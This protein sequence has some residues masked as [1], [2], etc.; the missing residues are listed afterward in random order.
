MNSNGFTSNIQTMVDESTIAASSTINI[1]SPISNST[2]AE[3]PAFG[4]SFE[5]VE[6]SPVV[7]AFGTSLGTSLD[8]FNAQAASSSETYCRPGQ[9]TPINFC[10]SDW[11]KCW[12]SMCPDLEKLPLIELR[13]EYTNYD[14][15]RSISIRYSYH[16]FTPTEWL[17]PRSILEDRNLDLEEVE[18]HEIE[19]IYY[20][21]ILWHL[22]SRRINSESIRDILN[23]DTLR[24]EQQEFLPIALYIVEISLPENIQ[25]LVGLDSELNRDEQQYTLKSLQNNC[26]IISNRINDRFEIQFKANQSYRHA[27]SI[28]E[29]T[30]IDDNSRSPII[31]TG[32]ILESPML[33]KNESV[34]DT[35]GVEI[36]DDLVL[37]NYIPIMRLNIIDPNTKLVMRP[38]MRN[39]ERVQVVFY[40]MNNLTKVYKGDIIGSQLKWVNIIP[41]MA[42]IDRPQTVYWIVWLGQFKNNKRVDPAK[43]TKESYTIISLDLITSKLTVDIN[44]K[45]HH[46]YSRVLDIISND[47]KLAVKPS[48]IDGS[49]RMQ[50]RHIKA[51]VNFYGVLFDQF[52]F[53]HFVQQG[54]VYGD[55][56]EIQTRWIRDY[57]YLLE[58]SRSVSE[59]N[60]HDY[61]FRELSDVEF[62]P[63]RFSIKQLFSE[64]QNNLH[65]QS[66][67]SKRVILLDENKS[68]D[69]RPINEPYVE[70]IIKNARSEIQLQ[71]F[72][73]ILSSILFL[74]QGE[75]ERNNSQGETE[76]IVFREEIIKL[77]SGWFP[78]V[79]ETD[80]NN[81]Q[82]WSSSFNVI[83]NPL[84]EGT[85]QEIE[86]VKVEY[87]FEELL[88]YFTELQ[89]VNPEMANLYIIE[90]KPIFPTTRCIKEEMEYFIAKGRG[91]TNGLFKLSVM[92]RLKRLAPEYKGLSRAGGQN[93]PRIL[94]P[95][96]VELWRQAGWQVLGFPLDDPKHYFTARIQDLRF[97]GLGKSNKWDNGVVPK[98]FAGY[99]ESQKTLLNAGNVIPNKLRGTNTKFKTRKILTVDG[100]GFLP[101][102]INNILRVRYGN[103]DGVFE[104]HGLSGNA[105]RSKNSA[106][107]C[108][109]TALL[110]YPQVL[111]QTV[112][113]L[114]NDLNHLI[115]VRKQAMNMLSRY[116][117]PNED[118]RE[119][120][121]SNIRTHL[122]PQ[123]IHPGLLRQELFDHT[124][125][126][127]MDLLVDEN[128]YFDPALFY[129]ALEELFNVN[130]CVFAYPDWKV[131]NEEKSTVDI[132]RHRAFHVAYVHEERHTVFMIK[133]DGAETDNAQYP[134]CEMI[135]YNQSGKIQTVFGSE[136]TGLASIL[137]RLTNSTYTWSYLSGRVVTRLNMY[138]H[139]LTDTL[140]TTATSQFIDIYGK[141]RALT[142]GNNE[143]TVIVPPSAPVNLPV[144][145][146]LIQ[147]NWTDVLDLFK[148]Q[149]PI[150]VSKISI[151]DVIWVTGLWYPYLDLTY[152]I[153]IPINPVTPDQL[154]NNYNAGLSNPL[155]APMLNR[156][157]RIGN[158]F[159]M[160]SIIKQLLHWLFSIYRQVSKSNGL[161]LS[162]IVE[163][164]M[165][166]YLIVTD[167]ASDV[168]QLTGQV[169]L[170]SLD[171]YSMPIKNQYLPR[172]LIIEVAWDYIRNYN[173]H[174]VIRKPDQTSALL[175]YP[176]ALREKIHYTLSVYNRDTLLLPLTER[177]T[178]T[179]LYKYAEDFK[180]S[181]RMNIFMTV[182][183]L[184]TW[185][186]D[187]ARLRAKPHS[188]I[189]KISY[190]HM[191]TKDPFLFA[192]GED[193][194][195]F[196]NVFQ[197]NLFR[198]RHVAE[199][200]L[201]RK[202]N[203]G[204]NAPP[205]NNVFSANKKMPYVLYT[206]S[207]GSTIIPIEDHRENSPNFLRILEYSPDNVAI[208]QSVISGVKL[209]S[210][211]KTSYAALLLL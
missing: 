53:A 183:E 20:V 30:L 145:N 159:R 37:N 99:E 131:S 163:N 201:K 116:S 45:K 50:M 147:A 93:K 28:I 127:I 168:Q 23:D 63:T 56:S 78:F 101:I 114:N 46:S 171:L 9:Y 66:L 89:M 195:I 6:V 55:E 16:F 109:M 33:Y 103:A 58:A 187:L 40:N 140:F 85:E 185:F 80:T 129:R 96:E 162:N 100:R 27:P 124:D 158:M 142:I 107:H 204:Y 36:F 71:R 189:S 59:K 11:W 164:F 112:L 160:S 133:N 82:Q 60:S 209:P 74:Y 19:D 39:G 73:N 43:A 102:I 136:L 67:N 44:F 110:K 152:G 167:D 17:Q 194:Y 193:I 2:P 126:E 104:R 149:Q 197:G 181:H 21:P 208:Q 182:D 205:I 98:C 34:D 137:K 166:Q 121:V 192:D 4:T 42:D 88:P 165:T 72:V 118:E 108:V 190:T 128:V 132:P 206:I 119:R 169:H 200:W 62:K 139:I 120:I 172:T 153:Y 188:I 179:G 31:I 64:T 29:N 134:Q 91:N 65:T 14:T 54:G 18:E 12:L 177:P 199:V 184:S 174:I 61:Y 97:M 161:D 47:I 69:Y 81:N 3:I 198:A 186:R 203:L 123:I 135:A 79:Q 180:Q 10:Q 90:G 150:A 76:V 13:S 52:T 148:G 175:V 117:V 155:P 122:L 157:K 207:P 48:P 146:D 170:D 211:P 57:I 8:T 38:T 68:T 144:R 83:T 154:P 178:L 22:R 156:S 51:K 92:G 1:T 70:I 49:V 84:G 94:Y 143:L 202:I 77:Y 15:S 111:S 95:E 25:N 191:M 41:P 75:I 151:N 26:V 5:K 24:L 113:V 7:P 138:N 196:Q 87:T 115:N 176:S 106:I 125:Q 210:Q 141:M 105:T 173:K 35:K 86:R 130:V 32:M